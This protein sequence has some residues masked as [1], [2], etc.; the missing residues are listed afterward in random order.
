MNRKHIL[1]LLLVLVLMLTSGAAL[2]ACG[3]KDPASAGD[4]LPE[5]DADTV[6]DEATVME[7][8]KTDSLSALAEAIGNSFSDFF[9]DEVSAVR[10]LRRALAGG[11]VDFLLA[12]ELNVK[13]PVRLQSTLYFDTAN[14]AWMA[15]S[16][17]S[18]YNKDFSGTLW[19]RGDR[20][21]FA[22]ESFL[23]SR[24]TVTL[25]FPELI[26]TFR[27]SGLEEYLAG[28]DGA[29]NEMAMSVLYSLLDI[30]NDKEPMLPETEV[31]A[32]AE[33]LYAVLG[34]TVTVASAVGRGGQETPHVMVTHTLN[35]QGLERLCRRLLQTAREY[36]LLESEVLGVIEA[37]LLDGISPDV[38]FSLSWT[39]SIEI[40]TFSITKTELYLTLTDTGDG[41]ETVSYF[42]EGTLTFSD[43]RITLEAGGSLTGDPM[44]LTVTVDKT[45]AGT[46]TSY[47]CR[48]GA[49]T[50]NAKMD[51]LDATYSYDRNTGDIYFS[52][53]AA[54]DM[55]GRLQFKAHAN[56]TTTEDEVVL[57]VSSVQLANAEGQMVTSLTE[58]DKNALILTVKASDAFP[59]IEDTDGTEDIHVMDLTASEW[60]DM[61][62]AIQT[63]EFGR[64]F[65]AP[66]VGTYTR[67]L[68]GVEDAYLELGISQNRINVDVCVGRGESVV[69]YECGHVYYRVAGNTITFYNAYGE[70]PTLPDGLEELFVFYEIWDGEMP[71]FLIEDGI[72]IGDEDYREVE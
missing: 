26:T 20:I 30:L 40:A 60:R 24:E 56:C 46:K 13:D 11:S 67:P 54:V 5:S 48:V 19:G 39:H 63:G 69:R 38:A 18:R 28:L 50:A 10:V 70:N 15:D 41:D 68:T 59:D 29:G 72:R 33:E 62:F 49:N 61:I 53:S 44:A 71:I 25:S 65:C 51:L 47:T 21:F 64:L 58:N 9:S 14:D 3:E 12:T 2:A 6:Y 1:S 31:L 57:R 32:L 52:G 4:T 42:M 55:D 22:G 16:V 66:L 37:E 8:V 34:E 36:E 43:D 7:A 17:Y 27:G 23:G 45:V 35:N